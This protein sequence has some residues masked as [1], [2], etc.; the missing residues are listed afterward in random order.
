VVV[1]GDTLVKISQRYYGSA[2]GWQPIYNANRDLLGP[3]GT[4]RVGSEL[5][6]P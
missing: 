4:L 5:R 3:N 2:T 6:I 1:P